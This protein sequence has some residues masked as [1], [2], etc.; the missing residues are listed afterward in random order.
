MYAVEDSGVRGNIVVSGSV[1]SLHG[2]YI[3]DGTFY[4]CGDGPTGG[5][6]YDSLVAN[7]SRINGCMNQLTIYGT[8]AAQKIVFSRTSGSYVKPNTAAETFKYGPEVWLGAP[9]STRQYD[10]YVSL[11]PIL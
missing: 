7:Q 3:T 4:T 8:V 6:G 2:N 5:Y 9:A 10:Y 11:P 1:T